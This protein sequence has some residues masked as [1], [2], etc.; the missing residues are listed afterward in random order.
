MKREE[1]AQLTRRK[2]MDNALKEF[3]AHGYSAGSVNN[4]YDPGQ[5]ISK[6]IIYHYFSSKDELFLACVEECFEQL[7]FY[8]EKQFM[9][10]SGTMAAEECLNRYFAVR[11]KFFHEYPLYQK[12][13][14]EAVLMPPV[15]LKS[16]IMQCRKPM[17]EMNVGILERLLLKIP[18]RVSL[19]KTEVIRIIL[20]FINFINLQYP[21]KEND[22]TTIEALEKKNRQILDILLNGIVERK[23]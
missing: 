14:M 23:E 8:M 5:G 12:I 13:F 4:I 3:S 9:Q 20:Q 1:K 2:I 6:G 15:H 22:V 18:L 21:L 16:A 7:R 17:E 19:D 11:M 10:Q